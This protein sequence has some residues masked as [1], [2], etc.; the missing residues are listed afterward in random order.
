M[1]HQ[2]LIH[3]L[4]KKKISIYS[5]SFIFIWHSLYFSCSL[6]WCSNL[7]LLISILLPTLLSSF[8]EIKSFS[9]MCIV[10]FKNFKIKIKCECLLRSSNDG[11]FNVHSKSV[12]LSL[13]FLLHGLFNTNLAAWCYNISSLWMDV[14]WYGAHIASRMIFNRW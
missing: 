3:K 2:I 8:S 12:I 5:S 9:T 14:C 13:C 6:A 10:L 1:Y 4:F 7:S 11:Q